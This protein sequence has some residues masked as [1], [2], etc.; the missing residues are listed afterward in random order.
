MT[1]AKSRRKHERP[2]ESIAGRLARRPELGAL[3]AAVV[4]FGLFAFLAG[5]RGFLTPT[6]TINYLE[7]AAQ[8][9][10]IAAPIALLM[11][12]GEFDLS[13]GSVIGVA[14]AFFAISI[15]HFDVPLWLAI[16]I[17][18]ALSAAVGLVN[19]ML[20]VKTGLPSFIVTLATMFVVRGITIAGT[21]LI[22]GNAVVGGVKRV[23]DDFG[24]VPIFAGQIAGVPVSVVWWIVVTVIFAYLLDLT[25]FGNWIYGTGG[26]QSAARAMG[27]PVQRVRI[28]LFVLASLFGGVVG[29]IMT[30]ESGSAD[31]L[32]GQ[33]KE[34]Q[35][36]T[37]VVIGGTL[38]TGG[39]GSAIGAAFGALIFGI[40]SQ[41]IYFTGLDG[42]WF[43][44]ILGVMLLGAVF[45]N[46]TSLSRIAKRR[47]K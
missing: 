32:R 43:Q 18:L 8:L 24:L 31:A 46:R 27:V 34:F 26:D 30:L 39:L 36:V 23:P 9:G 19:G 1:E 13:I 38:L 21:I 10:I 12:A 29:I 44:A 3:I 41:G 33:L 37:A 25:R 7:V 16:P 6:G 17:T 35:A 2:E 45:V 28:S 40:V 42:N 4:V 22:T 47:E 20:V 14:G 5:D 15:T 11:I